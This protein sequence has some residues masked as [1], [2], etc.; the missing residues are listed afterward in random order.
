MSSLS[1][2]FSMT[3]SDR[4]GCAL[5]ETRPQHVEAR[6]QVN[7]RKLIVGVIEKSMRCSFISV[8]FKLL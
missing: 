4:L 3:K 7:A 6:I 5:T 2:P 1:W 8:L